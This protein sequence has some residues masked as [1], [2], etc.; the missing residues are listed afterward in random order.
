MVLIFVRVIRTIIAGHNLHCTSERGW[1]R[2]EREKD[3]GRERERKR[4]RDRERE[5][6]R[7]RSER[8]GR[9][10]A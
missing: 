2:G 7:E 5:R 9:N 10:G 4:D 8:V 3:R 6:E 1:K